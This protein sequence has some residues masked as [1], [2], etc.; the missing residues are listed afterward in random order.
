MTSPSVPAE[1][2]G[3]YALEERDEE[4]SVE[5]TSHSVLV[6]AEDHTE[7]DDDDV[8]TDSWV[9]LLVDA[10]A[11]VD[12]HAAANDRSQVVACQPDLKRSD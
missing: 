5:D 10:P 12:I 11:V 3:V 8:Q 1:E 4:R 7:I 6:D 2:L 9:V